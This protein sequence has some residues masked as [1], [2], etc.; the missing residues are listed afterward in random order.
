[1]CECVEGCLHLH[2]QVNL[3]VLVYSASAQAASVYMSEC[4]CKPD[5]V[6]VFL[7]LWLFWVCVFYNA[8]VARRGMR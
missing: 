6:C 7:S 5:S 8:C 4:R 3:F 2:I 1:M